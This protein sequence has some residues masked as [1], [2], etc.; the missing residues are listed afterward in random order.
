M[1]QK[2]VDCISAPRTAMM[3][4]DDKNERALNVLVKLYML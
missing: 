2:K 4:R 1:G 3:L